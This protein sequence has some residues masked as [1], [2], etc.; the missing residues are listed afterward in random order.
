MNYVHIQS[1]PSISPLLATP[2]QLH[3]VL[4]VLEL[5]EF[6]SLLKQY[7]E[8]LPVG[9]FCSRLLRLYGEQRTSLLPGILVL[10]W[11]CTV[12]VT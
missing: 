12:S 1:H 7:R 4:E 2:T 6:A 8:D 3:S 11:A 5:R 9:Q 10:Y